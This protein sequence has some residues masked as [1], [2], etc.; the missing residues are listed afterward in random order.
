M[1]DP[2][3]MPLEMADAA[4]VAKELRAL[5]RDSLPRLCSPMHLGLRP[6]SPLPPLSDKARAQ[7]A[8]L[9]L[10]LGDRVVIAGQKVGVGLRVGVAGLL[11]LNPCALFTQCSVIQGPVQG[12]LSGTRLCM[13]F[14]QSTSCKVCWC[15]MC[16]Q[17]E[18]QKTTTCY[19]LPKRS[20]DSAIEAVLGKYRV[21][22]RE[23]RHSPN[24]Y[25]LCDWF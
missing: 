18:Q 6:A 7:L 23:Q 4:G 25:P 21:D 1:P 11:P 9:G 19:I 13:D 10:R 5:L 8:T 12:R 16:D 22:S 17:I 15:K 14:R 20:M 24:H 2:L 3:N